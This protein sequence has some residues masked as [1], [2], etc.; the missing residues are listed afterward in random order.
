[1]DGQLNSKKCKEMVICFS[2]SVN[3]IFRLHINKMPLNVVSSFKVLGI[4]ISNKLKWQD[5]IELLVTKASKR[6]YIIRVLQR[7]VWHTMLPTYQGKKNRNVQKREFRIIY[8][9][10]DYE[11][12]LNIAKCNDL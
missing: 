7:P 12:A 11:D 4:T 3:N 8:P 2:R 5:N 1:M 6:L 9:A 10:T